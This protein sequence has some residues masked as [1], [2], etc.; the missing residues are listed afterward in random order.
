MRFVVYYSFFFLSLSTA[1][2]AFKSFFD[3]S[4]NQADTAK[5]S[6]NER[7]KSWE[8]RGA[9]A[10]KN[11]SKGWSASMN[12]LQS[13]PN[14]YRIHLSGPLG[15]G[16][17]LIDKHGQITTFQDGSKKTSS[18]NA[19]ELLLKQTGVRLPVNNLYYW[20]RGLAA[21]GRVQS[22]ITDTNKR[23]KSLKQNNYS[24]EFMEYANV[25]GVFLPSKIRL[26][27][28]GVLVKVVIKQ[29]KLLN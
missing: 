18:T 26:E 7:V 10:A 13:G 12:W 16:N 6:H 28:N 14:S 5:Q 20:I 3:Q 1:C 9:L 11:K 29:W 19:E 17:V 25:Q 4:K 2:A 15:S 23:L 24:I 22:K 21:P 27:G 8:I